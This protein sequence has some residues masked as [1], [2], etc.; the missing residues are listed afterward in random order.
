MIIPIFCAIYGIAAGVIIAAYF[1]IKKIMESNDLGDSIGSF[2]D[3]HGKLDVVEE[4]PDLDVAH[5]YVD[6]KRIF[7]EHLAERKVALR[8][9]ALEAKKAGGQAAR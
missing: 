3:Y 5:P 1:T 2:W 4:V 8:K 6:A 7:R 9:A